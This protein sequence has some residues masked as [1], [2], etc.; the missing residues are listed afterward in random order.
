MDNNS[1]SA[2]KKTCQS[3]R[4]L[5]NKIEFNNKNNI[6]EFK[7]IHDHRNK[8]NLIC[9]NF[10]IFI[11]ESDYVSLVPNYISVQ[12]N[13]HDDTN[14][15]REPIINVLN[16]LNFIISDVKTEFNASNLNSFLN[17]KQI[18]FA[19]ELYQRKYGLYDLSVQSKIFYLETQAEKIYTTTK[20]EFATYKSQLND[21]KKQYTKY[22]DRISIIENEMNIKNN[23]LDEY[24]ERVDMFIPKIAGK[25]DSNDAYFSKIKVDIEEK[26]DKINSTV[27]ALGLIQNQMETINNFIK[28][29]NNIINSMTETFHKKHEEHTNKVADVSAYILQIKNQAEKIIDS[30]AIVEQNMEKIQTAIDTSTDIENIKKQIQQYESQLTNLLGKSVGINLF[31]TFAA[32]K[33]ELNLPVKKWTMYMIISFIV[34]AI[35]VFLVINNFF[36]DKEHFFVDNVWWH[37]IIGNLIKSSPAFLFIFYCINQRNK[38][39]QFQ[40]EYAFK[41]SVALTIEAYSKLLANNEQKDKLILESVQNIYK[42][43]LKTSKI[44]RHDSNLFIETMKSLKETSIEILSNIKKT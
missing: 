4:S 32:R 34:A 15:Y 8:I 10:I 14:S 25:I 26:H 19:F 11:D 36:V 40:E 44:S 2:I 3:I 23:T 27:A 12:H 29:G 43:P 42:S 38:E 33:K 22:L 30:R 1:A 20:D 39:R 17:I 37:N 5:T 16:N 24:I 21:I 18:L 41:A 35:W 9:N 13:D 7:S 31:R 6:L 28:D